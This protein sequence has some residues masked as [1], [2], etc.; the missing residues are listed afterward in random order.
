MPENFP[1]IEI[2]PITDAL[3][4]SA[5]A[6]LH[7]QRG[8]GMLERSLRTRGFF[9]P[10]A[11]AGKNTPNPIVEAGN[12]TLESA[13]NAGF[14]EAIFI[15]SD[16][17][18]PI[19]HVREDLTPE[20]VEANQ[21]AVED[22]RIAEVSLDWSPGV[23]EQIQK[24]IPE[25]A[26]AVGF[27]ADELE[28]IIRLAR[29]RQGIEFSEPPSQDTEQDNSLMVKIKITNTAQIEEIAQGLRDLLTSNPWDAELL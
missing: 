22:N 27:E 25:L 20:S 24:N 23:L 5:N 1:V 14:V 7:T 13:V 26:Q 10:I 21:L 18:R 16:G 28:N 4:D 6:N 3:P 15:H 17:S 8:Q 2:R 29:L 9:R 11:A 19:I 12:L